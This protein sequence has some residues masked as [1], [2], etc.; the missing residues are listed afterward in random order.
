MHEPPTSLLGCA[1]P[2]LPPS[3]IPAQRQTTAPFAVLDLRA[4][5]NVFRFTDETAWRLAWG[6]KR[7]PLRWHEAMGQWVP[8]EGL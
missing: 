8:E 7:I 6:V 5:L 4:G 3:R 1:R 2:P